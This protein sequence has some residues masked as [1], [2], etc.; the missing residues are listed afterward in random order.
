MMNDEATVRSPQ[1][2]KI[3]CIQL[4]QISPTARF[5]TN[6]I[7]FYAGLNMS[8]TI[9]QQTPNLYFNQRF[10]IIELAIARAHH[11]HGPIH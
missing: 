10:G 4:D 6:L 5:Q 3:I 1:N 2:R 7:R 8:Q 9:G 11:V